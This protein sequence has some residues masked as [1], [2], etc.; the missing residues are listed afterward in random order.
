MTGIV[1]FRNLLI[2]ENGDPINPGNPLPT[3][4]GGGG[5]GA[6][7]FGPYAL[8]DFADGSTLYLGKVK[9]DG[10]WLLQKYDQVIGSMRYANESNNAGVTTY[11]SA[12]G[13]KSTLNYDEFQVLT[14]V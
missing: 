8:N 2:D 7:V 14:G 9:S 5:G 4:G 11:T 6:G 1:D 10:T 12:W 13:N 3:T